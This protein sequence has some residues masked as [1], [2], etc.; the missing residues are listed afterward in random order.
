MCAALIKASSEA[1]VFPVAFSLNK[2]QP[3]ALKQNQN[4]MNKYVCLS[5]C[6]H[7][8]VCVSVPV[9]LKLKSMGSSRPLGSRALG[10]RSSSKKACEQASNGE[11]R[12]AGVYSSSREHRAMASGGVRGLNT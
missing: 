9:V 2:P 11:R 10:W 3:V 5:R 1:S 12:V 4:T 8:S 7:E 6:V